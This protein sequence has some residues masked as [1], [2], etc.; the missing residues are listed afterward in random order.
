MKGSNSWLNLEKLLPFLQNPFFQAAFGNR[1]DGIPIELQRESLNEVVTMLQAIE[2]SQDAID[3]TRAP[4]PAMQSWDFFLI[5]AHTIRFLIYEKQKKVENDWQKENKNEP[6]HMDDPNYQSYME[7]NR[8]LNDCLPN[9]NLP[10]LSKLRD[11]R[12]LTDAAIASANVNKTDEKML[13]IVA[14]EVIKHAQ[15]CWKDGFITRRGQ[16]YLSNYAS[17][18]GSRFSELK[19][20]NSDWDVSCFEQPKL[21]D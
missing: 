20:S 21:S 3:E 11:V 17:D 10:P 15:E 9:N 14:E 19:A 4:V 13:R 6:I 7:K 16:A 1:W 18:Q 8:I 2:V 12:A 5:F